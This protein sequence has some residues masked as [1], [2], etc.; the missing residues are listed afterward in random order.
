MTADHLTPYEEKHLQEISQRTT[1]GT[2]AV[3]S[4]SQ[5]F[6]ANTHLGIPTNTMTTSLVGSA[7]VVSPTQNS[8]WVGLQVTTASGDKATYQSKF[9]M[10]Y[11]AYRTHMV[12]FA[13]S[14]D[15]GRANTIQRVGLY[16]DNDGFYFQYDD[17]GL[18]VAHRTST[19]GS[20]VDTVVRMADFNEDQLDGDGPSGLV[21]GT[22]FFLDRGITFG[23]QYNWYG[24]Q[25]AK[26]FLAYGGS[27][28][29]LHEMTFTGQIAGLP[30]MR[31]A[32]LPVRFMIENTGTA[33]AGST[34]RVG[35]LSHAVADD[36]SIDV[37]FQFSASTGTT[38]TTVNSQTVWTDILA[39]RPKTTHNSIQNRALIA[40]SH[41]QLETRDAGIEYRIV[42]NVTYTGGTWTAV[43]SNSVAEY[44]VSPGTQA[45][46]PRVIDI[47]YL[48][49]DRGTGGETPE[50]IAQNNVRLG[51]DTVTGDQYC[52]VIQ[53]RKT[54]ATPDAEAL[55]AITWK[56][57]Y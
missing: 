7:S 3:S 46:T 53:A 43:D 24:T 25:G 26:F 36:T 42:D 37:Y 17:Q 2:L 29:H 16:D 34:M 23:I 50:N 40:I 38:T 12:S 39:V 22:D 55:A 14:F 19:S 56:E 30:F 57:E 20:P 52:Y 45:G 48:F 15:T 41:W 18:A 1:K 9:Y 10:R 51:L 6:S 33:A 44:S 4:Y 54:Q 5:T 49:A 28:V 13:V 27:I 31:S 8:P 21:A 47:N 35:T 32:M 11:W